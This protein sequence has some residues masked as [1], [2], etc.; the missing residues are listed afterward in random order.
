[1]G[2]TLS[3][4]KAAFGAEQ[5]HVHAGYLGEYL[6]DYMFM[7]LFSQRT[8]TYTVQT[9]NCSPPRQGIMAKASG[10]LEIGD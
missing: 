9:V 6:Q 4:C 2:G 5:L 10:V 8:L 1:M 3:K 7:R